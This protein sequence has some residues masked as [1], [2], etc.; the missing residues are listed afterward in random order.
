ML[1][2]DKDDPLVAKEMRMEGVNKWVKGRPDRY[3]LLLDGADYLDIYQ[4]YDQE[5]LKR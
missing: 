3:Q 1:K 4:A 2:M 5:V